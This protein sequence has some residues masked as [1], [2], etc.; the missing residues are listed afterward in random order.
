MQ[1]RASDL[2]AASSHP[3]SLQQPLLQ[4][5]PAKPALAIACLQQHIS[6]SILVE[7]T[8]AGVGCTYMRQAPSL[9]HTDN[10]A[11]PAAPTGSGST[12][13]MAALDIHPVPCALTACRSIANNG[14]PGIACV[15]NWCNNLNLKG[16]LPAAWSALASL[17]TL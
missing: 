15:F 17:N 13:V 8:A 16:T 1:T 14:N 3:H 11:D 4:L 10:H 2:G 7:H 9:R 5:L 6:T 12:P